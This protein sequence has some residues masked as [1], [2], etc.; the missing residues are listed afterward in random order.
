MKTLKP[1]PKIDIPVPAPQLAIALSA[2]PNMMKMIAQ[3]HNAMACPANIFAK[4]RIINANGFVKIPKSSIIGING[5][6]NFIHTGTSGQNIS[7]QYSFVPVKLVMRNV[8][9]PKKKVQ[10]MLPVKLPPPG[11]K[12]TNP[13]R[14]AKKMKKK[15]VSN[16]GAYFGVSSPIHGLMTS[17]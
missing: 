15:Q 12:G 3:K 17:S 13:I 2:I 9:V 1:T 5:T 16:H 11:G 10:V 14:F 8:Q 7:F 6:G 4:R